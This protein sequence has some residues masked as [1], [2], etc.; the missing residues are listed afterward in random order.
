LVNELFSIAMKQH[1]IISHR[2]RGF[3]TV[4]ASLN[5]LKKALASGIPAFEMDTRFTKDGE[6]LVHHDPY[7]NDN[8]G[9][10]Q[11]FSDLTYAEVKAKHTQKDI[12]YLPAKLVEFLR[13]MQM[14]NSYGIMTYLDIKEFGRE[15]EI[16]RLFDSFSLK[17]NL[18]VVSWLPEVLFAIHALDKTIPLCFSHCPLVPGS[19]LKNAYLRLKYLQGRKSVG[20]HNVFYPVNAY[21]KSDLNR[22]ADENA[23]GDDYEHLVSAPLHGELLTVLQSVHGMVCCDIRLTNRKLVKLYHEQG[24]QVAV[25]SAKEYGEISKCFEQIGVDYILSDNNELCLEK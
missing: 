13:E 25:Y 17:E 22:Y 14:N 12:D 11:Y 2:L 19:F 23:P 6:I 9:Q 21:N 15:K 7:I 4:D 20:G 1:R 18:V 3:D 16:L 24:I 8:L 10:R 5:G